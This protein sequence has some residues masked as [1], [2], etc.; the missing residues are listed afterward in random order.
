M[1]VTPCGLVDLQWRLRECCC[2]Y[3]PCNASSRLNRK[4]VHS[5]SLY[6]AEVQILVANR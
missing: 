5:Q 2:F 3:H 1:R 4:Y 6:D